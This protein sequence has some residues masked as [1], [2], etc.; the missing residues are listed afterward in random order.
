MGG[1]ARYFRGACLTAIAREQCP[2]VLRQV[3]EYLNNHYDEEITL[4]QVSV[5]AGLSICHFS[6][7]FRRAFG[8]SVHRYL[9]LVRLDRS[10]LLLLSG[11]PI[12]DVAAQV[13]FFDQSHFHHAFARTYGMTPGKFRRSQGPQPAETLGGNSSG[14]PRSRR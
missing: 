4:K 1:A 8:V 3:L 12:A 14:R 7:I 13:G 6:R 11:L 9:K 10:R 5:V 2:R